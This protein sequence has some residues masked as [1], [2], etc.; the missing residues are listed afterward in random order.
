[1]AR[2]FVQETS[3]GFYTR[4]YKGKIDGPFKTYNQAKKSTTGYYSYKKSRNSRKARKTIKRKRSMK[5]SK[6]KSLKRKS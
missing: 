3:N 4:T 1:M 6:K 2:I 5:K